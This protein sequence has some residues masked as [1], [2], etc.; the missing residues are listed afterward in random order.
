MVQNGLVVEDTSSNNA[1]NFRKMTSK[2]DIGEV[3]R[4][5]I[6]KMY[7]LVLA[8]TRAH[9]AKENQR[10]IEREG[11]TALDDTQPMFN[12]DKELILPQTP[13]VAGM[14]RLHTTAKTGLADESKRNPKAKRQLRLDAGEEEEVAT[15]DL[16][17][18][19]DLDDAGV[20]D[21]SSDD[22]ESHEMDRQLDHRR[23]PA[24]HSQAHNGSTSK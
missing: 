8:V 5:C 3:Y 14:M 6:S 23:N 12:K 2:D 21:Q 19:Y 10:K 1:L 15:E 16:L 22:E 7:N 18:S 13:A 11:R 17:G 24:Q 4:Q 9:N 20:S